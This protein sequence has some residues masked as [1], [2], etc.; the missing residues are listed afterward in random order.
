[1]AD[2]NDDE[3]DIKE[4]NKYYDE[5]GKFKWEAQSSSEEEEE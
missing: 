5:E 1:M 2:Q 4:S 3:E